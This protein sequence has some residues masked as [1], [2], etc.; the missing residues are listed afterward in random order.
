MNQTITFGQDVGGQDVGG[1]ACT[2]VQCG[3]IAEAQ[4][5]ISDP[6]DADA[7]AGVTMTV[8]SNGY[9]CCIYPPGSAT[10][11]N[12]TMHS[13]VM[14]LAGVVVPDGYSIDH[15]NRIKTDNRRANLR[16]VKQS[17]QNENRD[18][19]S[20]RKP[21]PP[22][23]AALGVS[24]MP[25]YMRW[26][27][28]EKKFTGNDHPMAGSAGFNLTGTKAGVSMLRKFHDCVEKFCKMY[29]VNYEATSLANDEILE[30]VRLSKQ[31]NRIVRS[32]HSV[33]PD[34]FPDGKYI[35]IDDILSEPMFCR[36]LRDRIAPLV[37]AEAASAPPDK[38]LVTHGSLNGDTAYR[39]MLSA[40]IFAFDWS[41]KGRKDGDVTVTTLFDAVH[42]GAAR[43]LYG[44][45]KWD[46][47]G[48]SPSLHVT[49]ELE[50]RYP[51]LRGVKKVRLVDF[52]HEHVLKKGPVPAGKTIVPLNY[53]TYDLREANLLLVDGESGKSYKSPKTLVAPAV[54]ADDPAFAPY[55][56][57]FRC[58]PRG[59]TLLTDGTRGYKFQFGKGS[60]SSDA[61]SISSP[62]R[63]VCKKFLNDVIPK[64]R[65]ADPTF[66]ATNALYQEM[67]RSYEAAMLPV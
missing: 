50:A 17:I 39:R 61:K 46:S 35:D 14:E 2:V 64:M 47:S 48:S 24:R 12:R 44:L 57:T 27:D 51:S 7:T 4:L 60:P 8:G 21:P 33:R 42:E 5:V 55:L 28:A 37:A 62:V 26:D 16:V 3:T 15:I 54:L 34:I 52:F 30:R 10:S 13:V 36:A 25:R 43:A 63:E 53:K 66:D 67:V 45:S 41:S 20:D 23:I 19:R 9:V 56:E 59:V 1:D 32:A 65:A 22:P 11:N 29:E 18:D 40:S 58:L 6:V 31:Y 49:R 38:P